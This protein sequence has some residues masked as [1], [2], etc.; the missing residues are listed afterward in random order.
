MWEKAF[1]WN[2][3]E[4]AFHFELSQTLRRSFGQKGQP[5]P[6]FTRAGK[7]KMPTRRPRAGRSS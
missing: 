3:E 2:E 5:V 1:A 6:I 7:K 4:R